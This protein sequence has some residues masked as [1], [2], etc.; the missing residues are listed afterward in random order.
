[1]TIEVKIR[2]TLFKLRFLN[3]TIRFEKDVEAES[4][5]IC[6][7]YYTG[8]NK[9]IILPEGFKFDKD[10]TVIKDKDGFKVALLKKK[11]R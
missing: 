11:A 7:F 4:L 8:N 3:P 9:S 6:I 5:G 1:M 10:E 2:E